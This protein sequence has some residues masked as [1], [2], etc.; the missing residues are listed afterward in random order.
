MLA[1][2]RIDLAIV[3]IELGTDSGLDLLPDIRDG[4]GNIIPVI[5]F[6]NASPEVSGDSEKHSTLSK[7]TS[8]LDFLKS[9]VRDR[10]GLSPALPEKRSH[11]RNL[12]SSCR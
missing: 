1:T 11:N 12:H 9:T 8:P 2:G 5:I 7:M 6:S 4:S 3:D 10:L